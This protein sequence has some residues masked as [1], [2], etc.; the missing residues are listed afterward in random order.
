MDEAG[1]LIV[2]DPMPDH[3]AFEAGIRPDDFILEVDGKS[4][5]GMNLFE[6]VLLIRGPTGSTVTLTVF[7]EGALE[8]FEVEIVRSKIELEV[9]ESELME[10]DGGE[11]KIG[12]VRLSQ[13][14]G[15][16]ADKLTAAVES[17]TDQGAASI[18]FDLRSNPGGLLSEA[19]NVSSVF[20]PRGEVVVLEK[21]KDEEKSFE[22]K[23]GYQAA[24]EIPLVVL[25]NGG[26]ASASEIVAGAIQDTDR[27]T[28]IGDQTFGK[29]S[30]QLPH[31]LSDGSE[32]RV[33]IAEWLT[34]AGRQIHGE[35]ISPDVEV[36][37]TIEDF[38]ADRDPQLE[39]AVN[40]LSEA[41]D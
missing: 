30:V 19:V 1:R 29:G 4:L 23:R 41:A 37:M 40:F 3:P 13:F 22:A 15:G 7:R 35:G 26:S 31:I 11:N 2:V 39:A 34:P 20:L 21:L 16:A 14:S 28:I 9:V 24:L 12:Y 8:P 17:L 25:V 18:I 6:A 27:G 5:E 38:E 32:L 10:D 33:T 36:E